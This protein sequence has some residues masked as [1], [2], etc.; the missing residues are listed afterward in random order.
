MAHKKATG[1][2]ATQKS[3]RKGKRLGV[4]KFGGEQVISGNIIV[5]QR[6]RVFKA[7]DGSMMGKDFTVFAVKEGVVKFVDITNSKKEI[8]VI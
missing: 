4:K 1:S 6:G 5:R 3:N 2:R 7:G 8:R